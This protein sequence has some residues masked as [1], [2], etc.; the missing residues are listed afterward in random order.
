[1]RAVFSTEERKAIREQVDRV[2]VSSLFR[3]SKRCPKLLRHVVEHAVVGNTDPIKERALGTALFD[4]EPSYDTALHPVVRMT[5]VEIRKRLKEYYQTP[6]REFEIRIELPRGSYVPTFAFPQNNADH[7]SHSA[8]PESAIN[9]HW[10]MV[11]IFGLVAVLCISIGWKIFA[12]NTA[13][14]TFWGPILDS[15]TPILLCMPNPAD[16]AVVRDALAKNPQG[17]LS[18]PVS[19]VLPTHDRTS[20]SDSVALSSVGRYLGSRGRAF[21]VRRADN[22]GAKDL[23]GSPAVLIGAFDNRWTL[24]LSSQMRFSFAVDD[25]G[26]EYIRD[27]QNPTFREWSISNPIATPVDYGIISRTFAPTTGNFLVTVAGLGR[28]A[29]LAAGSCA[30]D[31]VCME[32]ARKFAPDGWERKN[33]EIVI[34]TT[35]VTDNAPG[36]A[37]VIGAYTW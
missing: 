34:A 14:A 6:G 25:E 8:V 15:K 19:A 3:T 1:V 10:Q 22:I 11:A 4:L 21:Y 37:R 36:N 30:S 23:S 28:D 24:A 32:Q 12:Q 35:V 13:L 18:L 29:T 20:F 27:S 17:L 2:V 31:V 5:A 26:T 9:R 7:E 33:L 16:L